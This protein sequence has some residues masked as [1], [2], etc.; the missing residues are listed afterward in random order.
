MLSTRRHIDLRGKS[1]DNYIAAIHE[2]AAAIRGDKPQKPPR[3][4][5]LQAP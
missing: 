2:L 1:G 5:P 4:D 3:G